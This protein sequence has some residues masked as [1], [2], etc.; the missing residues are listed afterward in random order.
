V[1]LVW[2]NAKKRKAS[3]NTESPEATDVN[4]SHKHAFD[5]L[6][7]K[8]ATSITALVSYWSHSPV[9]VLTKR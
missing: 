8:V 2:E 9:C 3:R 7:D 1:Y 4:L 6:T 5:D